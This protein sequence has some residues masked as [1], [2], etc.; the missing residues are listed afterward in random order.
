MKFPWTNAWLVPVLLSSTISTGGCA[1]QPE[2]E[3]PT[4]IETEDIGPASDDEF[5]LAGDRKAAPRPATSG[6]LPGGFPEGLPIYKPSTISDI[7]QGEVGDYVQFMS[8]DDAA[9]VRAWYPAA[10]AGAGWSVESGSGGVLIV[11]RG[12]RSARISIETSGPVALIR[13][14]Y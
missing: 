7:G 14:E 13:V 9:T 1:P 10:L 5:D 2:A 12:Q 6:K 8:Q 3:Q 11:S 4:E